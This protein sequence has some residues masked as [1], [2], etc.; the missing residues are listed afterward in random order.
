MSD[1]ITQDS[2]LIT[3]GLQDFG[4]DTNL[5]AEELFDVATKAFSTSLFMAVKAGVAYMAAQEALKIGECDTVA[6]DT[7]LTFAEWIRT[8]KLTK[9]RVY[10]VIRLAKGYLAIPAEQRRSYLA[11]GKYKAL[12]LASIEPAALAELVDKNPDE[13]NEFALM[14]RDAVGK[15][16]ANLRAQLEIEQGKN[17]RLM[18]A[19]HKTRVTQFEPRTEDVRAECMALQLDAELPLNAMRKL[20]EEEVNDQ[21]GSPEVRLRLEQVW[22]AAHHAAAVAMDT[23]DA[24][25]DMAASRPD[26]NDLPERAMGQHML[27][28]QEAADWLLN[29]PLIENRYEGKKAMREMERYEAQSHGPGRRKGSK[30]KVAGD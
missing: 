1:L 6:L 2:A 17:Q 29:K 28:P 16:V 4:I 26:G 11:L 10:E 5:T 23:L 20:F 9:E 13:L 21:S 3:A 27:S 19:V 30:N 15:Y 22:V 7:D 25:R 8:N 14:S 18:A 24:L 12:K